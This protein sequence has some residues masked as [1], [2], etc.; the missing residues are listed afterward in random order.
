MQ[1]IPGLENI[2]VITE[3][4]YHL[5]YRGIEPINRTSLLCKALKQR[6]RNTSLAKQLR[7]EYEIGGSVNSELTVQMY[8]WLL[9][10]E[11]PAF[12]TED[13]DGSPLSQV[14]GF[15]FFSFEQYL[16][17]AIQITSA[18][19]DMHQSGVAFCNLSP[20]HILYNPMTRRLKLT[21]F[22][23]AILLLAATPQKTLPLP[24]II[25]PYISPEQTG[26]LNRNIDHRTDFY[27]LGICLYQIFTGTLPFS[28][29]NY[30]EY[31]HLHIAKEAVPP[32]VVN[33]EI[34]KMVSR[35]IQKLMDKSVENRYQSCQGV[36]HD[37][38]LCLE[39]LNGST[40]IKDFTP[41]KKDISEFFQVPEKLYGRDREISIILNEL[42]LIY[43]SESKLLLV[44]GPSGI[45][46][47]SLINGLRKP[48]VK[49]HGHFLTG[50]FDQ[51]PSDLPYLPI[52]AAF[53]GFINQVIAEGE[54]AV[55]RLRER[56]L[57]R[58]GRRG[59]YICDVIPELELIIGKQ[60][61]LEEF[62][63]E[64]QQ[65]RFN[66]VLSL[67]IEACT[68]KDT[69]L[70][71]FLDDMQWA[72]SG[73]LKF[74]EQ[75]L[76]KYR[77]TGILFLGTYRDDAVGDSHPLQLMISRVTQSGKDIPI[78]HLPPLR[79]E[80]I[81]SLIADTLFESRDNVSALAQICHDKTDGNP[82]FI[83]QFLLAAHFDKHITYDSVAGKWL[84][85]ESAIAAM[86]TTENLLPLQE[87]KLQTFNKHTLKILKFASCLGNS[88]TL[89]TLTKVCQE[90]EETVLRSLE[91]LSDI[92]IGVY[93][94][95]PLSSV[96][97]TL[98]DRHLPIYKFAHDRLQRAVYSLLSSQE[99][100][101]FH[102]Q[103]G[104][105][106]KKSGKEI[107]KYPRVFDI[108]GHL[109]IG[110]DQIESAE[111][112]LE[113]ARMN[114]EAG[115]KALSSSA[116]F[117]AQNYLQAG[118]DLLPQKSWK[119]E[120]ALTLALHTH[121]AE[122]AYLCNNHE[123]SA[124]L[125]EI[126]NTHGK[127]HLDK[128]Y[129]Y[130]IQIRSLKARNMSTEAVETG[131]KILRQFGI[132][133]PKNPGKIR[134]FLTFLRIKLLLMGSSTKDIQTLPQLKNTRV[135]AIMT[136]LAD[137]GTATYYTNSSLLPSIAAK[138]IKLSLKHGNSNES[139][140][141]G[142]LTYGFLEC[143]LP[144]G[145]IDTGYN[146]GQLS[147]KLLDNLDGVYPQTPYLVNNLINH[148]KEP[149]ADTITVMERVYT[150]CLEVGDFEIASNS[151]YSC[152][153][154]Y[155][156]SGVN[157]S[158]LQEKTAHFQE[159]MERLGHV[160]PLY[161]FLIFQQLIEN[162]KDAEKQPFQL[163]G[164]YYSEEEYLPLHL[165]AQ[166][167]TTLFLVYLVRLIQ[168]YTFKSYRKAYNDIVH[169]QKYLDSVTSSLFVPI[170]TFYTALTYI[171]I[172]R[173]DQIR[174][175]SVLGFKISRLVKK[176][177]IW[178]D[179]CPDS[180]LHKYYIV[181]AEMNRDR[182]HSDTA[183]KYYDLAMSE[184]EGSGFTQDLA[185]THEL[186]ASYLLTLERNHSATLHLNRA[187]QFYEEWGAFSKAEQLVSIYRKAFSKTDSHT[188]QEKNL[189]PAQ[190]EK[191]LT[192]DI[193]VESMIKATRL[194]TGT[195]VEEDL[196]R[197][198]M[199]TV[200]E[201]AGAQKG[202]LLFE[203]DGMWQLR[204]QGN[205]EDD[206]VSI[207]PLHDTS[208]NLLSFNIVNYVAR[209]KE[210]VVLGNA[211]AEGLFTQ[212][213]YVLRNN[214]KSI[215][216][217]PLIHQDNISCIVYLENNI[218]YEAFSRERQDVLHMLG[219]HAAI[220]LKNSSLYSELEET[221]QKLHLE[222]KKRKDTQLQLLHAEKLTALGRL[223]ASIAHEFGNPLIGIQYLL[224]DILSRFSLSLE[225][226]KLVFIGVE[227]CERMKVLI[228]DMQQL[229]RPS[230]GKKKLFDPH[231]AIENVL[232]FQKKNLST[233]GINVV[234]EYCNDF[235]FIHAV[236]DQVTQV[237]VNLTLNAVDAMAENGGVLTVVT[238]QDTE[239]MDIIIK[240]TG[241][242]ITE[243]DQKNIFEPFYSTKP[244]VE[245]TGLGLPV[246]YS[247]IK[248]HGG[249]ITFTTT[250]GKGSAF[251]VRLPNDQAEKN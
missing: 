13:F 113:L 79:Q 106:L 24:L 191:S 134:A 29:T 114:L 77:T 197:N 85:N 52:I 111:E 175:K 227:E 31:M 153:Y 135:A 142:Y 186:L 195:I 39:S 87:R 233:H 49:Q 30:N 1:E 27:S 97:R 54:Q 21:N 59:K 230:S 200:I 211:C 143:G 132:R 102:Y 94:A 183:M 202:F 99:I 193:D 110:A 32:H 225:D 216:C 226:E 207:T 232:L 3:T 212:D 115:I 194:L 128:A 107:S 12:L 220:S 215:L 182:N 35:I 74:L 190:T 164:A 174:K 9:I 146:I 43:S 48:V 55:E 130:S 129:A 240:D 90:T 199:I 76:I 20:H 38:H 22:S 108:T 251:H 209:T 170:Y 138:A 71:I 68:A 72:D 91:K 141:M 45:G 58:L 162:L 88:F 124:E 144:F 47:S 198:L 219:S 136:L 228:R 188:S 160:V 241:N 250:P 156:F 176:L 205:L 57:N 7:L 159:N 109:N 42:N 62:T 249:E 40:D 126:I 213:H 65:R 53:Q 69:P 82:F 149:I 17:I 151:L 139:T 217:I 148:W 246:S 236:E 118:L 204:L 234:R 179:H 78:L 131:V 51:A 157:L 169:A 105:E 161:R 81:Q 242:G 166:D 67:F 140:S 92:I 73:T 152:A 155:F 123:R 60:P 150:D 26:R 37:L 238:S 19:R 50:K 210:S 10:D 16:K 95:A 64:E 80:N 248:N 178:A 5:T 163:S 172:R 89:Q 206:G 100:K 2:E 192:S 117:S 70:V 96:A 11:A 196:L 237:L 36:L 231:K 116:N 98:E 84:W 145:N 103:I 34:P 119:Q 28:A 66:A 244:D 247:I 222:I 8:D 223:S 187:R 243:E 56:I 33:R 173:Q 224:Q 63:P 101:E 137:I 133:L 229:N 4:E 121:A 154:R 41:G 214:P 18:L 15:K 158:I 125:F 167:R 168:N 184:A 147:L 165:K 46:K 245:G 180:F 83:K 104:V 239:F 44:T 185:L 112:K 208:H 181:M 86:E 120:Y 171:A 122:A 221:I 25:L 218:T 23:Q 75:F 201:S 127:N 203:N 61:E 93:T 189:A 6:F 235:T 177:R 14:A